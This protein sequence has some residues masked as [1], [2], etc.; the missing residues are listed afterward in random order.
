MKSKEENVDLLNLALFDSAEVVKRYGAE[1]DELSSVERELF[2]K[3][4]RKDTD[5]LDLGVGTGRTTP[6]LRSIARDYVGLDYS[7]RMITE[8]R[9]IHPDATLVVGDAADLSIF[10]DR[11]FDAVVFSYNGID[12]LYPDSKRH[13]SLREIHR[14]LREG[15]V[16]IFS[17]HNA[18]EAMKLPE[19]SVRRE[20]SLLKTVGVSAIGTARLLRRRMFTK[21]WWKGRGYVIDS[22][23]GL[24]T[25]VATP[26]WVHA[27]AADFGFSRLEYKSSRFP[28]HRARLLTPWY[29]Y[30]YQKDKET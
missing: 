7:P 13:K 28:L 14:V 29:Y 19:K 5:I 27:E 16:F 4:L 2:S 30:V 3:Y 8:C 23:Q 6:Y 26:A 9:R 18:H 1:K 12:Y 25:H 17:S 15:A 24:V 22:A 20:W 21:A 10:P 11:S